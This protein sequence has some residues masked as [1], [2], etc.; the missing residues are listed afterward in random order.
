M[1]AMILGCIAL[2]LMALTVGALTVKWIVNKIKV[3]KALRYIKRVMLADIRKLVN[4]CDNTVTLNQLEDLSKKGYTH[5]MADFDAQN[6]IV[7]DVEIIKDTNR[8]LDNEVGNLL[9]YNGM[10][11][12]DVK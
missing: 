11:L 10:V 12:V 1:L 3:K 7:G 2:G 8:Q 4:S 5:V 9:G 6:E